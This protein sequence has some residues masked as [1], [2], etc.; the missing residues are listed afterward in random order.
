[1]VKVNSCLKLLALSNLFVFLTL[2]ALQAEPNATSESAKSSMQEVFKAYSELQRYLGSQEDFRSN[3]NQIHISELLKTMNDKFHKADELVGR[4]FKEQG[5]GPT[6]VAVQE[7]LTDISNRFNEGKKDYALWRIRSLSSYCVTCHTRL[8][9]EADF[10]ANEVTNIKGLSLPDKADYMFATRQFKSASDLY[11]QLAADPAFHMERI[12]ALR[13]WLVIETRVYPN[14]KNAITR[15]ERVKKDV[16]LS[17]YELEEVN[18]WLH[19]LQIWN[20]EKV[21]ELK[22]EAQILDKAESLLREAHKNGEELFEG[23]A[24]YVPLLRASA[25][26][27][28]LYEDVNVTHKQKSKLL[29]LLGTIYS[30]MPHIFQSE[31]PSMFLEQ[32]IREFPGTSDAKKAF[33]RY[34]ENIQSDFTGSA[35][36]EIPSDEQLK[37][38]ELKRLAFGQVK[39]EFKPRI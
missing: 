34:Q 23:Q 16:A 22:S 8:K 14:P 9:I 5:L 4:R 13:K 19:S 28:G 15:L 29:F 38:E 2:P 7:S 36:T 24:L 25:L 33:R 18:Q 32:C 6:L 39:E 31:L 26:L 30:D 20:K 35:G 10:G 1:M 11:M 27:H 37:L 12:D 21:S 17:P 3:A